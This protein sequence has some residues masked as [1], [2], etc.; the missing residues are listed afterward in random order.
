MEHMIHRALIDEILDT[1]R[2]Q[3]GADFLGLRNH[4]QRVFD[5][6]IQLAKDPSH[7]DLECFAIAC[8]FH[9][10]GIWVDK[11]F[12][13]IEPSVS[14]AV[15]HLQEQG[16]ANWI[17]DVIDMIR[18]HHKISQVSTQQKRRA[19]IFRKADWIDVTFGIRH[20]GLPASKIRE[21]RAGLVNAGFHR[22]LL[23]LTWTRF[24][25]HPLS[26]LPM[27]RA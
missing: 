9:D 5:F 17:P 14:L 21:V 16:R 13:Y 26:P 20:F 24:K 22:S 4:C 7:D 2:T 11:T 10:L 25:K 3:I 12:D 15:R 6:C 23:R 18:D 27:L 8:A 19:E 1:Y